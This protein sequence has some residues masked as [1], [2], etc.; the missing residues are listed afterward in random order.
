MSDLTTILKLFFTSRQFR[1]MIGD[2]IQRIICEV[3][4]LRWVRLRCSRDLS[5]EIPET[6]LHYGNPFYRQW[7]A[8]GRLE[9]EGSIEPD[10][11]YHVTL[12]S[13]YGG[14]TVIVNGRSIDSWPLYAGGDLLPTV[15]ASS[16]CKKSVPLCHRKQ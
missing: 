11:A 6:R 7:I 1:Q 4:H 5:R 10:A 2:S 16:C 14:D 3:D 12:G 15:N 13:D 9:H 8:A